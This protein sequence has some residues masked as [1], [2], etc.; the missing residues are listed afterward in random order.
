MLAPEAAGGEWLALSL[1]RLAFGDS[2]P[3]GADLE[4]TVCAWMYG[5]LDRGEL[6]SIIPFELAE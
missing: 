2:A 6:F 5:Q 4:G 1:E 3:A